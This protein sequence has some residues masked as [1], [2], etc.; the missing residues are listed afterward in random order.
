[1]R[2]INTR[3]IA[4]G[5]FIAALYVVLT[6]VSA[7]FGLSSGVIQIR[8]SEMLCILPCFTAS[9]VPG[10]FIGC[11][12]AN[13]ITGS[14]IWDT[15]F[16]SIAT[17]A[18]AYLSYL[19]RKNRYLASV[20]P[21]VTNAIAVP[22]LLKYAYGVPGNPWYFALTVAAGELISAGVLGQLLYSLAERRTGNGKLQ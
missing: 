22:L 20:P 3:F 12:I 5:G 18:A 17:L 7:A 21:V 15:V 4:R 13:L 14:V 1:M 9:A 11:I 16:G 10:L 8:L 19:L 2:N 6:L